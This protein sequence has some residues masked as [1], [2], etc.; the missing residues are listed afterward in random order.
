MNSKALVGG[1]ARAGGEAKIGLLH[2]LR[3]VAR[4]MY[5]QE[6]KGHLG[7]GVRNGLR[8]TGNN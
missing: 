6:D 5:G 1:W 3:P 2:S 4:R 8:E 7:R